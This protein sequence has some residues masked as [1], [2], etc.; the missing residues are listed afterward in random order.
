MFSALYHRTGPP[1]AVRSWES[2]SMCPSLRPGSVTGHTEN[3]KYEEAGPEDVPSCRTTT[4][5]CLVFAKC[6]M[7]SVKE[8]G[9]MLV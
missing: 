7:F 4:K 6:F 2:V 3:Y 5:R 1:Q 8:K 9:I